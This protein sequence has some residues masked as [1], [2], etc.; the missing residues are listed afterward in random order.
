MLFPRALTLLANASSLS[1]SRALAIILT[2]GLGVLTIGLGVL[3][4]T[5]WGQARPLAKCAALSLFAHLLLLSF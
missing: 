3:M 1:P 5:R 2:T 4:W